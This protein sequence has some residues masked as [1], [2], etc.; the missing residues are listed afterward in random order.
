MPWE[1]F[2]SEDHNYKKKFSGKQFPLYTS[3]TLV[4]D[5]DM[6]SVG[7]FVCASMHCTAFCTKIRMSSQ[8]PRNSSVFCLVTK[9]LD[10][11][12]VSQQSYKF[13]HIQP[14]GSQIPWK[15][16]HLQQWWFTTNLRYSNILSLVVH[17]IPE[18]PAF[19]ARRLTKQ[20]SKIRT[21]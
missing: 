18:N 2:F 3:N 14:G 9:M 6:Q 5:D 13:Q 16:Q 19:S 12:G 7:I 4:L 21:Y 8:N 10:M 20:A 17:K 11:P 1:V 15:F